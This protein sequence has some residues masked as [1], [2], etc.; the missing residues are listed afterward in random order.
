[1]LGIATLCIYNCANVGTFFG[2]AGKLAFGP[3][4]LFVKCVIISTHHGLSFAGRN[5]LG[6][7]APPCL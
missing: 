2:G 3:L 7:T 5:S 1:M 4:E 6:D